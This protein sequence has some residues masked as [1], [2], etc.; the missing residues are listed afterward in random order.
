MISD[1]LTTFAVF[2]GALALGFIIGAQTG[3]KRGRDE[4]WIDSF[5]SAQKIQRDR[6]DNAGQFKRKEKS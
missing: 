5:F 6:R 3:Y 2:A 4:Q 1:A